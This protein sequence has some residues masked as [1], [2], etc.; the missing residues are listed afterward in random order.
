[1]GY[2]WHS[3]PGRNPINIEERTA[4]YLGDVSAE[5]IWITIDNLSEYSIAT[6]PLHHTD[7]MFALIESDRIEARRSLSYK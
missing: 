5:P 4:Y 7:L 2:P 3:N 6:C 1:M